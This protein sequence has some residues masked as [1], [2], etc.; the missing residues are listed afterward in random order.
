MADRYCVPISSGPWA[1]RVVGSMNLICQKNAHSN[2]THVAIIPTMHLVKEF[3]Q[4]F[5]RHL[6]GVKHN[7]DGFSMLSRSLLHLYIGMTKR[8]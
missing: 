3:H 6:L 1:L 5:I 4:R 8:S 7:L 2:T